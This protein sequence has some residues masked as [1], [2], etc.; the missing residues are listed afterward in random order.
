[1]NGIELERQWDRKSYIWYRDKREKNRVFHILIYGKE[2]RERGGGE[3]YLWYR[4]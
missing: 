4:D 3:S 1:M 2:V